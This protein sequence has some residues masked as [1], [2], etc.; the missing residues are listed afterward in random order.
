MS[1]RNSLAVLALAVAATF[2]VP[3]NHATA[4]VTVKWS[5]DT[6][7]DFNAGEAKNAFITSLGEVRPG[8]KTHRTKVEVDAVWAAIRAA[9]GTVYLGTDDDGRVYRVKGK[10]V[11]KFAQ[12]KDAV[13]IVSLVQ[14][15]GSVYAGTM[16]G[17]EIWKVDPR[18]GKS[19][20]VVKLKG[21]ETVWSMTMGRGGKYLY[22]GTGPSGKLFRVDIKTRAARVVFQQD[23]RILSLVTSKDGGIW[24][25]TSE[26]ALVLRYDPGKNTTRAM[27]DFAG[28]EITTMIPWR[29]GVIVAANTLKDPITSG[30]KTKRTVDHAK[31]KRAD[32]HKAKMPRTGSKPG[33][34]RSTSSSAKP[35]RRGARKGRG[36]LYRVWG[37]GRL[38]Q[39]HALTQTYF[40]SIA[41]TSSGRIYAGAADKG[42]VYMI[43]T[44]ES[45]STAYDVGERMVAK[46][47]YSKRHGLSFVTGDATALYRSTG[48]ARTASYMSKVI[49]TKAPSRFGKLVW[50]GRGKLRMETRTGNTATPDKAWSRWS[51]P[52]RRARGLGTR[53]A[54]V[55]S[56]P[57]G[58][59]IQFRVKFNGDRRA[60]LR[61]TAL[62][63]LPQNRPTRVTSV[64][65][66]STVRSG[67][68]MTL[69]RG[70]TKPRSPLM[71]VRWAV[72][73]PDRDATMYTLYVRRE[74]EVLWRQVS[75][76]TIPLKTTKFRW[77][78]ET[79]QDGYYRLR[80]T[81]SDR[82]ANTSG[83]ALESHKTT[84]LF[85]VDNAKPR[86]SA[87]TIKYPRVSARTTDTLSPIME[88]A[89]S[90]DN[91]PWQLAASS[92]GLFDSP[93]EI[94]SMT[95]PSGLRAGFHTLTI[96]AMDE[97]GNI[98]SRSVSFQVKR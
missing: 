63:Y 82:G 17:G 39:L 31:R 57:T 36:A 48:P 2:V 59:Y 10:T 89:Y 67:K 60:V 88:A 73:N 91:G 40:T 6:Y 68:A 54:G 80:V 90:V 5:V 86:V 12:I 96:R 66:S 37:D 32:G 25:G 79:F 26:K 16:P 13:A 43:D 85:V 52:R 14:A 58:R 92:D 1:I 61:K 64:K 51:Q 81:A 65:V 76:P 78:T 11:S 7:R 8:W 72:Y 69:R 29:N 98:G 47:L 95:L 75:S 93:T 49:D 38:E 56:S 24:L 84:G 41:A 42:R 34:D 18:T 53:S 74:G 3:A 87:V 4:V 71:K 9:D 27:V 23:K 22:A 30:M 44:D 97:A 28:N 77:N 46:L 20:K 94:L 50:H 83:R 55:I 35:T 15:K 33:A 45:V 21:A 70:A 19:N 62:Y